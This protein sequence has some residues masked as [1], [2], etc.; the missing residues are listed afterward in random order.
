MTTIELQK[1][2]KLESE[3]AHARYTLEGAYEVLSETQKELTLAKVQM[4]ALEK[5][6]KALESQLEFHQNPQYF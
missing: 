1:C 6:V 3:L 4:A 2:R 5:Q